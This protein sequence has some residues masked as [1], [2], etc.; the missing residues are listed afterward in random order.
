MSRAGTKKWLKENK[1]AATLKTFKGTDEQQE[2]AWL[3]ERTK[4]V[5]GSEPAGICGL[6]SF[7]SPVSIWCRKSGFD[8]P[9][10]TGS[11]FMGTLAEDPIRK[12]YEKRNKI[13]VYHKPYSMFISNKQPL[14]SASVDGLIT[15]DKILVEIKTDSSTGDDWGDD[16]TNVIPLYY[17]SQVAWNLS[18]LDPKGKHWKVAHIPTVFFLGKTFNTYIVERDAHMEEAIGEMQERVLKFWKYVESGEHPKPENDGTEATRKALESIYSKVSGDIVEIKDKN[19]IK[20]LK[21]LEVIRKD[22]GDLE[23]EGKRLKNE[24]REIIG[25]SLGVCYEGIKWTWKHQSKKV[26]NN[27]KLMENYKEAY[28]ACL[29]EKRTRV[30]R[31]HTRNMRKQNEPL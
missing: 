10:A 16:G 6:S 26:V 18:V 2:A 15:K 12:L 21:R 29:E 22:K 7:Q 20:L 24:L 14:F 19:T 9:R 8:D 3:K 13:E 1:I 11:Q 27:V 5:G 25:E 31:P 28:D 4:H 23:D 17:L 30:L